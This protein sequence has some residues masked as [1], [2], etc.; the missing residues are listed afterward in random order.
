[1]FSKMT[2]FHSVTNLFVRMTF[3]FAFLSACLK[4]A[5]KEQ[6]TRVCGFHGDCNELLA[7][8]LT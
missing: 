5:V 6:E 2:Y 8:V 4:F 1:M 7:A 3:Y